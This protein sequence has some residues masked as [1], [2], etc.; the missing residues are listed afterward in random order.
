MFHSSSRKFL[1][2]LFSLVLLSAGAYFLVGKKSAFIPQQTELPQENT[3]AAPENTH[4]LFMLKDVGEPYLDNFG[5][6]RRD[7]EMMR[8]TGAGI[9]E[10]NFDI[11]AG[12]KD[13]QFLLDE[14]SLAGIKVILPAG[15]G[16]AEWGYEC[17]REAKK[18]QK[19]KWE[20]EKVMHF[21]NRWKSHPAL[22]AWDISNEGGGNFP[23]PQFPL[24]LAQL[25]QAYRDVKTADPDHP[26]MIRMNG[27]YFYD[28]DSDF[29]RAGNPFGKDSAD[30]VMVN[31]YSNVDEYFQDF[32]A[33]VSERAR[34]SILSLDPD[35]EFIIA[36]GA[37][38][39]PPL[40][41]KPPLSQLQ[42][43]LESARKESPLAI[44]FFKYGAKGA[45][46]WLP[47]SFP[48]LWKKLT[49]GAF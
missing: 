6:M 13:V 14:A 43:D 31:A 26:A 47:E 20:K 9:I 40:W 23:N 33:T 41:K 16:E 18:D 48:E 4:A 3:P 49:D 44:A 15:S 10:G 37:W 8:S 21:V 30:I 19:P 17:D 32:V 39:E 42:N 27:W 2:A 35:T 29:F 34:R 24:T 38:E 1:F 46:W 22:F 12:E 28:Y 5:L 11:C 7:F 45:D 25:Q 36:L